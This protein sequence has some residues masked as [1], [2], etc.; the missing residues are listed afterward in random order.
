[1]ETDNKQSR[2]TTDDILRL[3][4]SD[5]LKFFQQNIKDILEECK[6]STKREKLKD[7]LFE[8]AMTILDYIID[9]WSDIKVDLSIEG[10]YN[11]E[12]DQ[13][14]ELISKIRNTIK[15][16]YQAAATADSKEDFEKVVALTED[17]DQQIRKLKKLIQELQKKQQRDQRKKK[18]KQQADKNT[19]KPKNKKKQK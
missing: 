19:A 10:D 15:D 7:L 5:A 13:I 14:D 3:L 11:D 2:S 12:I 4:N 1:M 6:D 9:I 18:K 8:K 17:I 16:A